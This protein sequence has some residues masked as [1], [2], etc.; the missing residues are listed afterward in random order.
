ME[1]QHVSWSQSRLTGESAGTGRGAVNQ[2]Q[3]WEGEVRDVPETTEAPDP[4]KWQ[5]ALTDSLS[6]DLYVNTANAPRP[7]KNPNTA[8]TD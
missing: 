4:D 7:L 6:S 8:F 5:S 2:S 3:F 1:Q